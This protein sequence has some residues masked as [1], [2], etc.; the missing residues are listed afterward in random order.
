MVTTQIALLLLFKTSDDTKLIFYRE[1]QTTCQKQFFSFFSLLTK[2]TNSKIRCFDYLLVC[3]KIKKV[4]FY[5]CLHHYACTNNSLI[6]N[7]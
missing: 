5:F 7:N 1:Y 2:N 4:F 6:K 3:F